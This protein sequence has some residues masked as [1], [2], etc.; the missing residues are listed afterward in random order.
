MS[1]LYSTLPTTPRYNKKAYEEISLIIRRDAEMNADFIKTHVAGIN[2]SYSDGSFRVDRNITRYEMAVVVLRLI[3]RGNNTFTT[4][5][6]PFMDVP[7]RHWAS[8]FVKVLAGKGLIEG[9][10]R[11]DRNITRYKAAMMLAKVMVS[12]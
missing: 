9:T 4:T 2:K 12:M 6:M 11:G 3:S 10:F 1:F 5:M 8:D 7:E